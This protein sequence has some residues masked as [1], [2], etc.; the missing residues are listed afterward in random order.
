M[1]WREITILGYTVLGVAV[2]AL[3]VA[4]GTP[5]SRIPSLRT[6]LGRVMSTRAG[7]V[8]V[9]AAWAWLGLHFFA[10]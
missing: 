10:L 3:Q 8:A 2:V 9:L 6:V 7:R 5:G 1:T 4:S